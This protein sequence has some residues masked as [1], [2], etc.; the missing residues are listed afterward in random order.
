[1]PD[2][3]REEVIEIVHKL[4]SADLEGLDLSGA[5]LSGANLTGANLYGTDLDG[6]NLYGTDL[7]G[8]NLGGAEYNKNTKFPDD[9]DPEEAGMVLEE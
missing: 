7:G 1:M 9:F 8:A 2:F 5:K 4:D 3:T 6:A